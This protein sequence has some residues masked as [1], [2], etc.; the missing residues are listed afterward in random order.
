MPRSHSIERRMDRK[1]LPAD[2]EP[3]ESARGEQV[4]VGRDES[5]DGD[6][7]G[8]PQLEGL[9]QT[10]Q[11]VGVDAL[12]GMI[13]RDAELQTESSGP[14][15][16]L[17]EAIAARRSVLEERLDEARELGLGHVFEAALAAT[18]LGTGN[19]PIVVEDDALREHLAMIDAALEQLEA[20]SA[21]Q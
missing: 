1:V 6:F 14:K 17:A 5:V 19:A 11:W 12:H 8:N 7:N 20:K 21:S 9:D 3:S 10:D 16:V 13:G 4:E 18:D 15:E 2:R